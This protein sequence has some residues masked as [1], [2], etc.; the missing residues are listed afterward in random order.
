M[1]NEDEEFEYLQEGEN[2]PTNPALWSRAKAAARSKFDKYPSA[3]ANLFASKWYKKH[4]GSWTKKKKKTNESTDFEMALKKIIMEVIMEKAHKAKGELGQW[5][6]QNWVRVGSS[7]KVAGECGSSKDTSN[8][9][10][11]LPAAK[12]YSLSE[13]ERAATA[14]KKKQKSKG[15]T[16][17]FVPNTKKARVKST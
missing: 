14:K 6:D 17:Q 13:K 3:Y 9:D 1:S 8:P 4:G 5:L 11:C 10:R 7:G 16:K 15:G 12:A 2:T